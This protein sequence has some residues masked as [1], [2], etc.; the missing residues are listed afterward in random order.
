MKLMLWTLEGKLNDL[1]NMAVLYLEKPGTRSP[2]K[3][4]MTVM[5]F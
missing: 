1:D 4:S 2:S 5:S 3:F